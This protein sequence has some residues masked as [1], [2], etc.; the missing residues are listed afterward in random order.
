MIHPH[1][2]ELL[3]EIRDAS[4]GACVSTARKV[5]GCAKVE[6]ESVYLP[7]W[8]ILRLSTLWSKVLR[9]FRWYRIDWDKLY[10][11]IERTSN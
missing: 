3:C 6:K 4:K 2:G 8:V 5:G 1:S 10:I 9:T 11:R 7:S